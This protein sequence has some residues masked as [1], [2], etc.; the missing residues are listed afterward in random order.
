M[1]KAA[2]KARGLVS[3]AVAGGKRRPM[4]AEP[5]AQATLSF[6]STLPRVAWL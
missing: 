4:L 1:N 2:R 6:T 5:S 3:T